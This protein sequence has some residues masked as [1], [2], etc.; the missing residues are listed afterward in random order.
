MGWNIKG[1]NFSTA[2]HWLGVSAELLHTK[3]DQEVG[4]LL[5]FSNIRAI[6][7]KFG[8]HYVNTSH[9]FMHVFVILK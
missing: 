6:K 9:N 1:Q 3:P 2:L 4:I 5:A 7:E 8:K